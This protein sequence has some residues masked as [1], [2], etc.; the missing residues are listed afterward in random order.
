MNKEIKF[1]SNQGGPFTT[2]QNRVS[3]NIP[4]SGV[5]DLSNSYINLNLEMNVVE[6]ETASGVGIYN[7]DL[8][9]T[10]GSSENPKFN[11]VSLVKNAVL[12]TGI[13]SVENI[14]R[15]DILKQAMLTYKTSFE[16]NTSKSYFTSNQLAKPITSFHS[17]IYR[18]FVKEGSVKSKNNNI[19]PVKIPLGDIWDF[20]F[21]AE[22][23]DASRANGA[24]MELELNIDR[25]ASIFRDN[26]IYANE[27]IKKF[28]DI[29]VE[30]DVNTVQTVAKT[31]SLLQSPYYTGQKLKISATHTDGGGSNIT[32]KE[33]VIASIARDSSTGVI[34]LTFEQNWGN[35]ATGKEYSDITV[36][37]EAPASATVSFNFAEIIL[38][39]LP[40]SSS[41]IDV[42]EYSTF[43]TE[44]TNGNN[45][46]SFQNMYMVEPHADGVVICFPDLVSDLVSN[47]KAL[48]SYRL[49]LDNEDLTD[50]DVFVNTPLYYDRISMALSNFRM[51][52]KNIYGN[53]G[54]S[55]NDWQQTYGEENFDVKVIMAP[56]PQ[57]DQPFDKM[58]QVNLN[59][60]LDPGN[61]IRKLVLFKHLPAEFS[62]KK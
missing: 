28:E 45:I 53:N 56:L 42:I 4:A 14:R 22:E 30:G 48:E 47:N 43:S 49:R 13:S 31:T 41:D 1:Q 18:D 9:W 39:Q 37:A 11:N 12:K 6:N 16:E 29:N 34:S 21:Q 40:K 25:V 15:V 44:E 54:S 38:V 23:F 62:Y 17:G 50:R 61:G 51:R 32:D 8:G 20:C 58:L 2:A 10:H 7:M 33:V 36:V 55:K 57:K 3:F 24:S 59:A 60:G 46:E 26:L 35:L 52:L 27:N 5:Y 19:A